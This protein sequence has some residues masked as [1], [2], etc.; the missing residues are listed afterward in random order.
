[1]GIN[2][3]GIAV[4]RICFKCGAKITSLPL[5]FFETEDGRR[6]YLHAACVDKIAQDYCRRKL[7]G[8]K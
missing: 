5:C 1:M 3:F 7:E 2:F 4:R 8:K 6:V